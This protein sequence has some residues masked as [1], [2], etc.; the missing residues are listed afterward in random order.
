MDYLF[1]PWRYTYITGANAPGDCLFCALIQPKNDQT[2]NDEQALILH[3][4]KYC[5]VVLNAFPYTSG[6]VM[7]VPYEHLDELSKLSQPAAQELMALT[8]RLEGVLRELYRPDGVNLG[9]NI[10][11]AAGAGV[12]GHIHMHILPRWF[13]D[14]NF[15]SAI[16][17]TRVLPEDLQ[18]TYQKLRSKF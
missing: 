5:F 2:K 12:A 17:E 7:V 4:A 10:G 6:H 18:T 16:G 3:R 1:T 9:M 11:K 13:G 14:V 8:Q 15:M